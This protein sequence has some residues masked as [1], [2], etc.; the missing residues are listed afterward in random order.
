VSKSIRRSDECRQRFIKNAEN[1][2]RNIEKQLFSEQKSKLNSRVEFDCENLS[3]E[4]ENR[5]NREKNLETKK[6]FQVIVS[7][8][9]RN[10]ETTSIRKRRK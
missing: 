10:I 8:D 7:S 9:R 4:N 3:K 2:R 6:I 5:N 1:N